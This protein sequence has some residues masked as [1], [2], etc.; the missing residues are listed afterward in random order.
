V[1]RTPVT[2]A[3]P[4]S[5]RVEIRGRKICLKLSTGRSPVD[6]TMTPELARALARELL[7]AAAMTESKPPT[8]YVSNFA[9][10]RSSVRH[11]PGALWTIMANP[12]FWEHGAGRVEALTPKGTAVIQIKRGELTMEQYRA[13]FLA[14]MEDSSVLAPGAL[15]ARIGDGTLQVVREGDTLCCCCALTKAAAGQCHRVWAADLL[16][17][18]GWRVVLDGAVLE[19]SGAHERAADRWAVAEGK[20]RSGGALYRCSICRRISE[21]R[22]DDC[23]S[24]R[25]P[26]PS[27]RQRWE[28]AAPQRPQQEES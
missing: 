19:P 23:P 28:Q 21:G 14:E 16:V 12:R 22:D 15:V 24:P 2:N 1:K 17:A 27:C 9:S 3:N 10:H 25:L 18:A 6:I 4:R 7:E 11:G 20:S 8:I 13:Q 26:G 5:L